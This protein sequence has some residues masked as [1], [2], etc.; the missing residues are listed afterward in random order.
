ML[1]AKAKGGKSLQIR[2]QQ[3]VIS[4]KP[5]LQPVEIPPVKTDGSEVR[6]RSGRVVK[7]KKLDYDDF[8]TSPKYEPR[9]KPE[10][11]LTKNIPKKRALEN[12]EMPAAKIQRV[13]D[14]EDDLKGMYSLTI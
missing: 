6:S 13:N 2:R 12:G 4:I 9:N 1:L 11:T 7:A 5:L 8:I 10:E 14:V 3:Q